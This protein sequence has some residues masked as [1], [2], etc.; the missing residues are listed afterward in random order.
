MIKNQHSGGS[1]ILGFLKPGL[2]KIRY[3]ASRLGRATMV[4]S[5]GN[6]EQ[7]EEGATTSLQNDDRKELLRPSTYSW[8]ILAL[9]LSVRALHYGS[10]QTVGYAYGFL[11]QGSMYNDHY[12]LSLTYPKLQQYYGLICSLFFSIPYSVFGIFSGTLTETRNRKVL[13]GVA[14][15]GWSLS[16]YFVGAYDSLIVFTILRFTLG[17]FCSMNNPASYALIADYFPLKYRSTANAI[18]SS[19][20]YV[21]SCLASTMVIL[22]KKFGWRAMYRIQGIGGVLFGLITLLAMKEPI[23]GRFEQFKVKVDQSTEGNTLQSSEAI[24]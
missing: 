14:C 21:G 16:T 9:L 17:I 12:M 5:S 8:F 7:V 6:E 11:G 4:A 3:G 20:E 23:R 13:L 15:L 2:A 19:G 18:Q 1:S 24:E 10:R 22:I